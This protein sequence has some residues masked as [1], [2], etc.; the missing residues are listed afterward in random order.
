[1][2]EVLNKLSRISGIGKFALTSFLLALAT[3]F[4]ELFV[5]IT[6]ALE[7]HPILAL[8]NVLGANIANLSLVIGGAAFLG[9]SIAVVG[10]F[11]KQDIFYAFLAGGLPLI[12]LMDDRLSR[13]EGL[14]LLAIYGV[15]NFT[16]LKGERRSKRKQTVRKFFQRMNHSHVDRHL[17]WLFFGI[18]LLIFSA[19]NLVKIG[20]LVAESFQVPVLLIGLFLISIGTTLPELSFGLKAVIKKESAMIF[21]NLLGSIVANS[22]LI[23]G[24]VALIQP[25]YLDGGFKVYLVASIAY[26]VIF[27]IFWFFVR[28][29]KKLERWEGAVLL[30]AY[31]VFMFFEFWRL[32][33]K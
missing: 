26:I 10:D 30:L 7:K 13:V 25:I 5:G 28:T 24:L 19:D 16:V 32:D 12:F 1:L 33:G 23:L 18:A 2:V 31:F 3:S 22:T 6:S 14:L 17:A 9:G 4:P 15:Y 20:V 21:G 29:K 8:G 27:V 11:L